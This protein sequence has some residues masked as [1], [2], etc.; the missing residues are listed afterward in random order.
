MPWVTELDDDGVSRG[1]DLVVGGAIDIENDARN[2]WL[3]LEQAG[4]NALQ[5][6]AM[7]RN[8]LESAGR[9]RAGKVDNDA[10]GADDGLG[11]GGYGAAGLHFDLGLTRGAE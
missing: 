9:E 6:A 1:H 2:R 5:A 4:A 10:V 3:R 11:G 7:D 8:L